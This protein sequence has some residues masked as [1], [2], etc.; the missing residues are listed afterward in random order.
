MI[1]NVTKFIKNNYLALALISFFAFLYFSTLYPGV[2]GRVNYGDSAKWQFLWAIDGTPHSTG[3]PLY[4]ILSKLFGNIL[5]FLEPMY[6]ITTLS[7]LSALGTLFVL[8]KVSE[9]FIDNRLAR[10]LPSIILGGTYPFWSQATEAEVYTLNA[11]FVTL[12]I[13]FSIRFYKSKNTNYFLIMV[14]LYALS[15]GNHLTMITLLPALL[16]II[17][18]TGYQLIFTKK[19]I[20]YTLLFFVLGAPRTK[21]SKV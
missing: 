10:I 2:G 15:F 19:T 18:S 5:V 13:Y 11:L 1:Q 14:A 21:N 8:Y 7:T 3:Y 6:R 20:I 17:F 12:V 16:Y 4:L 9:E